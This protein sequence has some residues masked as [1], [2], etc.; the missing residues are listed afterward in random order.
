M[1]RAHLPTPQ[2]ALSLTNPR[3]A[4]GSIDKGLIR[5]VI[6]DEKNGLESVR[7]SDTIHMRVGLH[8]VGPY[9]P[10]VICDIKAQI[11]ALRPTRRAQV[12]LLLGLHDLVVKFTRL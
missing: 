8:R 6:Y 9:V 10:G 2:R 5:R 7:E 12:C 11:V 3:A 4:L 1:Y